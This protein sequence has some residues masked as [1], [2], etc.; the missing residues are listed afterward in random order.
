[1][2]SGNMAIIAHEWERTAVAQDHNLLKGCHP[3]VKGE[4]PLPAAYV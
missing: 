3:G 2:G 1:V 4:S